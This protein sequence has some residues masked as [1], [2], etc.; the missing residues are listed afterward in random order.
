MGLH[1]RVQSAWKRL[2]A[3][4][5]TGPA[6]V[7]ALPGFIQGRILAG[8]WHTP[9]GA[10]RRMLAQQIPQALAWQEDETGRIYAYAAAMPCTDEYFAYMP[11]RLGA[12][13]LGLLGVW[14]AEDRRGQGHAKA[15]LRSLGDVFRPLPADKFILSAEP[16]TVALAR[17]L[18]PIHVLERWASQQAPQHE[19]KAAVRA[20][21]QIA[22][23]WWQPDGSRWTEPEATAV[24]PS[25]C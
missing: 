8:G 10:F 17:P 20:K 9:H 4:T 5:Y 19:I 11:D 22:Q 23:A 18:M 25:V 24:A 13:Q 16:A 3:V 12:F 1:P 14:V 2:A 21:G 15:V 7:T 6:Q